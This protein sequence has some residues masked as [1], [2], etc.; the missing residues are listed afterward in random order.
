MHHSARGGN[1]LAAP[2]AF[3]P[4][5]LWSGHFSRHLKT[6]MK[7]LEERKR[8]LYKS[9]MPGSHPRSIGR[10]VHDLFCFVPHERADEAMRARA[11][12]AM[13]LAD[14]IDDQTLGPRYA[15][16]PVVQQHAS[17]GLREGPVAA[18]NLFVDGVAYSLTDTVVGFWLI[19]ALTGKRFLF[20]VVR[21]RHLCD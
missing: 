6:A 1:P 13:E 14:G 8:L 9:R 4:A 18:Y 20:M 3:D 21:K 2:Y 16:H 5:S 12:Y 10:V 17:A 15:A 7:D 11:G 19:D